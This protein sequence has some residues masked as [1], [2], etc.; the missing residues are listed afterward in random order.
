[1][2]PERSIASPFGIVRLCLRGNDSF[3][4]HLAIWRVAVFTSEARFSRKVYWEEKY[5]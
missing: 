1:M 4:G 5:P 2:E 3:I